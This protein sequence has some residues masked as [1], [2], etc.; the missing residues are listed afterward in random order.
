MFHA[1][2]LSARR[3]GSDIEVHVAIIDDRDERRPVVVR[4]QSF[5][6]ATLQAVRTVIRAELQRMAD[7]ENDQSLNGMVVDQILAQV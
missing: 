7:N 1:K 4:K 5:T 3:V 2:G 6:G